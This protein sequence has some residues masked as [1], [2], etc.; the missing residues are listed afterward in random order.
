MGFSSLNECF[1][2]NPFLIEKIVLGS[3]REN[4]TGPLA[5]WVWVECLLMIQETGVKPRPSHTKASKIILDASLLNSQHY[6]IRIKGK[7]SNAKKG[8][9]STPTPWYSN[10]WKVSLQVALDYG[11]PTYSYIYNSYSMNGYT[12]SPVHFFGCLSYSISTHWK[13]ISK[14]L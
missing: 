12:T 4:I 11:G 1:S 6:K 2:L 9:V 5:L 10:Y 7:W 13:T 3:S 14:T 8:V